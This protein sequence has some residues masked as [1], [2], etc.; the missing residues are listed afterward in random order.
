MTEA[1]QPY[2][3]QYIEEVEEAKTMGLEGLAKRIALYESK[4]TIIGKDA[5]SFI[6]SLITSNVV[7]NDGMF[8][9]IIT[10]YGCDKGMNAED[11]LDLATLQGALDSLASN[12]LNLVQ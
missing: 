9:N 3:E 1:N 2:Y 7:L 10:S 11:I 6:L 8:F 4:N 12:G 5:C